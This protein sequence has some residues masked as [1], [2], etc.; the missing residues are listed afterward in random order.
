MN[1]VRDGRAYTLTDEE[2][3][4]AHKEFV[5][6]FMED[7]L[8][9]DFG[10]DEKSSNNVAVN[11]YEHYCEGNGKTEYECIEWA[12]NQYEAE[13]KHWS[14]VRNDFIDDDN[15]C[16]IDAWETSDDNEEGIVIAYVDRNTGK[17][18]YTNPIALNDE[19]AQE[20]IKEAI[21]MAKEDS[22]NPDNFSSRKT[23]MNFIRSLWTEFGDVPM[24]PETENLDEDWL[25]FPKGTNRETIWH[26]FEEEFGISVASDLM[27][28]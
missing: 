5:T 13:K 14:E 26:W 15:I 18:I 7:K 6:S 20:A 3:M 27:H 19:L 12:Y 22:D 25:L 9:N 17:V 11:A 24:D 4:E 10:L 1:I 21:E 2:L 23:S 16:Y 28:V 8:I